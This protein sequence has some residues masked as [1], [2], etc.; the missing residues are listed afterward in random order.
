MTALQVSIV[1]MGPRGL[2]ILQRISDL[3]SELPEGCPLDVHLIDPGDAGQ[4]AHS[5]RQPGHL[6]TN[7]VASQVTMFAGEGGPSFTEWAARSG[8]REFGEAV[9]PTG[10]DAGGVV[11]EHTYLP[12]QILGSY[13]SWVFDR[14]VASLPASVRVVHHRDRAVDIEPRAGG[15]FAVHLEQGFVLP[16][17]YVFL[18]TGHCERIPTQADRAYEE[19]V[20][21]HADRNPWLV[22]CSN[23][24]PVERLQRIAPGST[25]AVQGLGLTAHDVISELTVG[26]GGQ[27]RGSG[28]EMEYVPSGR[29][30][31]I[32][33]FSRQC[34]PFSARGVNQK[35][36]TGQ[37]RPRFFTTEAVRSLRERATRLRNDPRLDFEEEVLPLLLREMGY[38]YRMA[39][40]QRV[41]PPEEYDLT[42]DDR[43]AVEDIIDPLRGRE[44]ASQEAFTKFFLDHVAVDLEQAE[45]GNTTSPVKAATDVVRDTRASLREAVEFSRLTPDSH[46]T[47]N[48]T[49][50]PVMNR[51]SF[52]PPRHRNHQLL[53]LIRAGAVDLA[54]GPGSQVVLDRSAAR[55]AIR[56][57]YQDGP[58]VRHAD[59][60]VVARLDAFHPEQDRSPL[61]GK[62]VQ[63]GLVRPY[64]NGSFKP[65]GIDIDEVGRPVTADGEPLRTVWAVGYPSRGRGST[66]THCPGRGWPRSSPARPTS[67]CAT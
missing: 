15:R 7:T 53:A 26:R 57:Q 14:T 33:L 22:Y 39:E 27:Y 41:I 30:P 9:Y 25:V 40:E 52:G 66:P 60:L 24:Y 59:A 63:R 37:H 12:R 50:V 23:P 8:Y 44:F 47:F 32:Q 4:G 51:V 54:G 2:S 56:T 55:F 13:L 58:E 38:A 11:G 62:L 35:G 1:G 17:D 20:Q 21:E 6:L 67:A 5:A 16:S 10:A 42:P 19:F 61:I 28:W 48:A 34:L 29:E 36:L 46:R 18:A 64:T 43:R 65:G 49:Y 3:A 45:L 31:V